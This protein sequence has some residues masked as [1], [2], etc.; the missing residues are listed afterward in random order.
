MAAHQRGHTRAEQW[1]DGVGARARVRVG[2]PWF[3]HRAQVMDQPGDV[4]L[5]VVRCGLGEQ[6]RALQGMREEIDILA[7]GVANTAFEYAEEIVERVDDHFGGGSYRAEITAPASASRTHTE[8]FCMSCSPTRTPCCSRCQRRLPITSPW[9]HRTAL[10]PA[11]LS[12]SATESSTD[13]PSASASTVSICA[14][15][16]AASGSTVWRHRT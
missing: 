1:L 12:T 8:P 11:S 7:V 3:E 6:L 4:K 5:G 15:S 9:V 14:S 2:M 16:R 13:A 10:S